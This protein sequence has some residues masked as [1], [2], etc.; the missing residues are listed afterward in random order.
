MTI[1]ANS[2]NIL[3]IVILKIGGAFVQDKYCYL[4]HVQNYYGKPTRPGNAYE[5]EPNA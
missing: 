3:L 5:A 4:R 2:I 1:D